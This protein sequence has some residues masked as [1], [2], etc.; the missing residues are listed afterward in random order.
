M[1][2]SIVDILWVTVSAGLIFLMQAGF[3]SLEFGLT[4]SKNNINVAI[5]NLTDLGIS[6]LLFWAFGYALMFGASNSGWF[7][8]TEFIPDLSQGSVWWRPPP[9]PGAAA[10]LPAPER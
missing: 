9:V 8:T 10:A 1:D 3:L 7:G 5:K 6:I 4:R 2:K